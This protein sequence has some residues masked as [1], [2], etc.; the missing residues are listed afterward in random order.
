MTRSIETQV[1]YLKNDQSLAVYKASEAGGELVPH[2]GNYS[3]HTVI[4]SNARDFD[5]QPDLDDEGFRL[6][7]QTTR[8]R[9]FY[10]DAQLGGY[11]A[12]VKDLRYTQRLQRLVR[13][14]EVARLFE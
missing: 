7:E 1:K 8:V 11:E 12:E 6:V 4:V 5:K 3:A 9:D 2:E 10:D 14:R 13:P